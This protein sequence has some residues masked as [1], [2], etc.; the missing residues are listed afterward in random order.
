M[1]SP[2]NKY[3]KSETRKNFLN[4]NNYIISL[5]FLKFFVILTRCKIKKGGI[6]SSITVSESHSYFTHKPPR[7]I[8][9][10]DTTHCVTT[11][12]PTRTHTT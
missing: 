6:I 7:I 2:I 11:Y 10:N 12:A 3:I 8:D 4:K 1:S 5:T 9:Q